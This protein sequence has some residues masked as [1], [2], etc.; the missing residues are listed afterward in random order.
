MAVNIRLRRQ[1]PQGELLAAHLQAQHAD[2]RSLTCGVPGDVHSQRGFADGRPRRQDEQVAALQTAEGA[3]YI[4]EAGGDGSHA[5][6]H[7]VQ[8]YGLLQ[9]LVQHFPDGDEI[10]GNVG[11]AYA[12]QQILGL[13]KRL[14]GVRGVRVPNRGDVSSRLN[15]PAHRCRS[16]DYPRE[17]LHVNRC[18]HCGHEMAQVTRPADL[19]QPLLERELPGDADLVDGFAPGDRATHTLRSTNDCVRGRNPAVAPAKRCG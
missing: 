5:P 14:F 9:V 8:P 17:V 12:E 19:I 1:Q 6:V 3:I 13:L 2:H 16:V 18:G 7:R 11:V 15:Q 10:T 4:R